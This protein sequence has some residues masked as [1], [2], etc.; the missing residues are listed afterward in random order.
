M[1]QIIISKFSLQREKQIWN[2][3]SNEFEIKSKALKRNKHVQKLLPPPSVYIILELLFLPVFSPHPGQ[4]QAEHF[5]VVTT[6]FGAEFINHQAQENL[7]ILI[8]GQ[9]SP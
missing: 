8:K 4:G 1:G 9:S 7:G 5:R 6:P 3:T 2:S